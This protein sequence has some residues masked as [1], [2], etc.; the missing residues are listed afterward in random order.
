[1]A[2]SDTRPT[3]N[4]RMTDWVIESFSALCIESGVPNRSLGLERCLRYFLRQEN[5]QALMS[6][7]STV[8]EPVPE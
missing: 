6:I 1:M 2:M 8:V 5:R 3:M 7:I 4:V